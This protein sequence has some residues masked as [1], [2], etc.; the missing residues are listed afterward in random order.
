[1]PCPDDEVGR[2]LI[3]HPDVA[4][5]I[6]T[7]GLDTA[8]LFLSWRPDL[9]LHAETSGKNAIVV[10]AAADLDLAV[11]DLVHSAF[12]HAGQK[13]S[14]ASLAIVEQSVLDDGRLL[15]K[16]A[17]ATR[18]LHVGP[19]SDPATDVGPLIHPPIG[20]LERALTR[21]DEGER[22]LVRP[23]QVDDRGYLWAPGIRVGVQPG[24]FFH[25]TECFGPVLGIMGARAIWPRPSSGRTPRTSG[26]PVVC[27]ASTPPRSTTGWIASR[28]ATRT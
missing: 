11:K 23:H 17:D 2:R 13:C 26:S 22:W 28:S 1:M 8:R 16:L 27:T 25:Q 10:T 21:L 5:V 9:R 3:T 19:A 12:G 24:S 14:A 6:L 4:A 15:A 7:G 18:S 20:A